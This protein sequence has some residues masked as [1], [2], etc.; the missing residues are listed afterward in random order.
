MVHVCI[1]LKI[2]FKPHFGMHI[3]LILENSAGSNDRFSKEHPTT[4]KLSNAVGV[5][6]GSAGM[7]VGDH[8]SLCI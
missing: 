2:S 6:R 3:F 7:G 8:S 1:F 4:T 5:C